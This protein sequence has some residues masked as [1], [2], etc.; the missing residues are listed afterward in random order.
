MINDDLPNGDEESLHETWPSESDVGNHV[1]P[2]HCRSTH[3]LDVPAHRNGTL[4]RTISQLNAAVQLNHIDESRYYPSTLRPGRLMPLDLGLEGAHVLVTGASGGIG[5]EITRL[6]AEQGAKVTAHYNTNSAT[7]QPLISQYGSQ[8][9]RALRADLTDEAAVSKLFDEATSS[10]FGAVHILILNHAISAKIREPVWKISLERW[11]HTIDVNL[12]SSF[13]VVKEYLKRLEMTPDVIK[14]RASV[15]IIGS[16]AGQFGEAG[17][18]DYAASKS[19]LMYGLTLSLKNEIVKIA[20]KARVNSIGPGWT[21]T[22]RTEPSIKN[23]D[24]VYTALATT[25][26]KKVAMPQDI[27][28]QVALLASQRVSGHITGQVLMIQGGMEG[29]LLNKQAEL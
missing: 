4:G 22:P 29:R 8:H 3:L 20:P 28:P 18:A 24:I 21:V 12:T 26:L 15:V 10:S 9:I 14:D 11:K 1:A 6:F 19:A 17:N 23:P 25:P 2:P 13:I 7:L 16:T 5:L 27:A